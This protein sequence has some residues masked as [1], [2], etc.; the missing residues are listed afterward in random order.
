MRHSKLDHLN[1]TRSHD[2]KETLAWP[3]KGFQTEQQQQPPPASGHTRSRWSCQINEL[4]FVARFLDDHDDESPLDVSI[5]RGATREAEAAAASGRLIS[6]N[7]GPGESFR[8]L[9]HGHT[10][11]AVVLLHCVCV[12]CPSRPRQINGQVDTLASHSF[13]A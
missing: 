12:Q 10:Q 1:W 13:A 4:R 9:G 3:C 11:V 8:R 2:D 7:G 6:H 5:W